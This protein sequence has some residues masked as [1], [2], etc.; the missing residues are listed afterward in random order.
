ML[1]VLCR[2]LIW[3]MTH[4]GAKAETVE[5][6]IRASHCTAII[7]AKTTCQSNRCQLEPIIAVE[8]GVGNQS[9]S[10]QMRKRQRCNIGLLEATRMEKGE[11][12]HV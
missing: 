4:T 11:G 10:R 9:W 7:K 2:Y 1:S 8:K 12:F 5:L 6:P 3:H